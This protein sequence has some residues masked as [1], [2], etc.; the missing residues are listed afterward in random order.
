M[1]VALYLYL[2][3]EKRCGHALFSHNTE[4]GMFRSSHGEVLGGGPILITGCC[5][6][7]KLGGL[8]QLVSLRGP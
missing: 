8:I 4:A 1:L 5:H 6:V 2:L 3:N 7:M